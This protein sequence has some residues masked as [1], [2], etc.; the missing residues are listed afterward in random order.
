MTRIVIKIVNNKRT[1]Y[2]QQSV[3]KNNQAG[4]DREGEESAE[5]NNSI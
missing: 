3:L 2:H 5:G 4:R 1:E